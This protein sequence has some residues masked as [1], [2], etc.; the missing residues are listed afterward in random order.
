MERNLD[1][2]RMQQNAYDKYKAAIRRENQISILRTK[3]KEEKL[4]RTFEREKEF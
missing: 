1:L 4:K 2:I 3:M